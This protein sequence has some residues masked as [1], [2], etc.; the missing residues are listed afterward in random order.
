M[1]SLGAPG[2]P[3]W[4]LGRDFAPKITNISFSHCRAEL[5]SRYHWP[6]GALLGCK[7]ASASMHPCI[8]ASMHPCI[9]APMH[10]CIH[11]HKRVCIVICIQRPGLL[12]VMGGGWELCKTSA[13]YNSY[14]GTPS[15]LT[16]PYPTLPYLKLVHSISILLFITLDYP[17][18]TCQSNA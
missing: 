17:I 3:I 8:H 5:R 6:A 7:V 11:A 9:H 15:D 13:S 12:Y 4:L 18:L 10:P 1:C 16:L 2:G 14:R